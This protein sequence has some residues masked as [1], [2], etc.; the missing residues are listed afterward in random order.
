MF[1]STLPH[2]LLGELAVHSR[3]PKDII[4]KKAPQKWRLISKEKVH[5]F[6]QHSESVHEIRAHV[7]QCLNLLLRL[8]LDPVVSLTVQPPLI[9]SAEQ[10]SHQDTTA[11]HA[12]EHVANNGGVAL[13][14][15][16]SVKVDVAA[17]NTVNVAP[18]NDEAQH[19][20]ALVDTLDV[21][22]DPGNGDGDTG[23]DAHCAQEC[24]SILHTRVGRRHQHDEAGNAHERD[25]NVENGS[26]LDLV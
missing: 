16:R 13:Q 21:V 3:V 12:D 15:A 8:A 2:G 9:L 5:L 26:S 4:V 20:T 10:R 24:A 1:M 25:A 11:K 18:S 22:G 7:A 6:P 23:I 19:N 14:V 17:H